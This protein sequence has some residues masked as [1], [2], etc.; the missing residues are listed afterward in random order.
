MVFNV[1]WRLLNLRPSEGQKAMGENVRL[2]RVLGSKVIRITDKIQAFV[3][4]YFM[5]I[6]K[7]LRCSL[8]LTLKLKWCDTVSLRLETLLELCPATTYRI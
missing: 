5:L 3:S 2:W 4:F 8:V 7:I 6:I 1:N